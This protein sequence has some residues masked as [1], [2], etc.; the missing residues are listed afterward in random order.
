MGKPSRR[1]GKKGRG[2]ATSSGGQAAARE[3]SPA[4]ST[5]PSSATDLTVSDVYISLRAKLEF[6]EATVGMGAS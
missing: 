5:P 4:E 2:G 1:R 3:W 6:H